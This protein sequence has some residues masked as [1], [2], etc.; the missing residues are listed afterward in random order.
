MREFFLTPEGSACITTVFT[1]LAIG[2]QVPKAEL[3]MA[4]QFLTG[5]PDIDEI[6]DPGRAKR[7]LEA[8][9]KRLE[10]KLRKTEEA[11]RQAEV[12]AKE[13]QR[14]SEEAQKRL[15][16]QQ[17][18]RRFGPLS[19]NALAQLQAVNPAVITEMAMRVLTAKSLDEVLPAPIK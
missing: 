18:E 16:L 15:V 1:Y 9:G 13:A 11:L 5:N 3:D 12:A 2:A 14:T 17:I 7:L 8:K 4:V 19:P 6:L 10:A